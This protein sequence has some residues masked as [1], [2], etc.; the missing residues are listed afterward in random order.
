[1]RYE[2]LKNINEAAILQNIELR[3]K[4]Q[5]LLLARIHGINAI[6][7]WNTGEGFTFANAVYAIERMLAGD[8]VILRDYYYDSDRFGGMIIE[9]PGNNYAMISAIKSLLSSTKAFELVKEDF[10]YYRI[11]KKV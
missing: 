9:A 11:V 10:N 6:I 3:P 1:M 8:K 5:M 2:Y 4:Q 7:P